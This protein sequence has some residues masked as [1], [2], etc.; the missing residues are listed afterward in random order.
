MPLKQQCDSSSGGLVR[1]GTIDDNVPV[2][3]EFVAA[4]LDFIQDEMD[5]S[6]NDRRV[7]F[8]FR[9]GPHI[10][11]DRILT[12]LQLLTQFSHSDPRGAQFSQQAP[13]LPEFVGNI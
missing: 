1:A 3:W 7:P 13:P 11:N 8:Q 4:L 10:E 9:L 6:S 12:G 5:R 2:V